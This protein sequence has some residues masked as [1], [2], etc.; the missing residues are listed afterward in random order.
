MIMLVM[1][2][3]P[4]FKLSLSWPITT[5]GLV[6]GILGRLYIL[7]KNNKSEYLLSLESVERTII[8]HTKF[9]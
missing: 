9:N 8:K 5:P 2:V 4:V 7:M 1:F 6:V 3:D